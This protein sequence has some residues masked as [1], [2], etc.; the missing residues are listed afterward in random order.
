MG[1]GSGDD[2]GDL[3]GQRGGE[4]G[5]GPKNERHLVIMEYR[6]AEFPDFG[7]QSL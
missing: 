4:G 1:G 6:M 5:G 2:D 3:E 7:P